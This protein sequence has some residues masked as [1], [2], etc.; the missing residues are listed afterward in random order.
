VRTRRLADA[1]VRPLNFTVRPPVT[2]TEVAAYF[3]TFGLFG[4]AFALSAASAFL[5][6]RAFARLRTIHSAKWEEFGAPA[7]FSGN[8]SNT[9]AALDWLT[10]PEA[11]ELEDEILVRQLRLARRLAYAGAAVFFLWVALGVWSLS[12]G[13]PNNRC[14]GP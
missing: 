4:V 9:K 8:R 5:R 1:S 11:A 2:A 10:S 6:Y 13:Q 14:R 7:F 12:Y 3:L